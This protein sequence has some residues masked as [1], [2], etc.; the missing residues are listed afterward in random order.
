MFS[1]CVQIVVVRTRNLAQI[2]RKEGIFV[3]TP[4]KSR[5]QRDQSK[6][7]RSAQHRSEA[8]SEASD[9]QRDT[10]EHVSEAALLPD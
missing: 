4:R 5:Q 1:A 8:E 7:A 6:A 2:H 9:K 10:T 3:E